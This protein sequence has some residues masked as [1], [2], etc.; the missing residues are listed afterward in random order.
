MDLNIGA[1]ASF[2]ILNHLKSDDHKVPFPFDWLE[3]AV[4]DVVKFSNKNRSSHGKCRRLERDVR[5]EGRED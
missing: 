4:G 2:P 3:V 5:D 1:A